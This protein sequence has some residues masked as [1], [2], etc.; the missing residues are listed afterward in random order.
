MQ[1]CPLARDGNLGGDAQNARLRVGV[2][3]SALAMVLAV[4]VV[5]AEL[6]LVFRLLLFVPFAVAAAGLWAALYRT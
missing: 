3:G 2:A 6:G 5:E 1:A 4:L